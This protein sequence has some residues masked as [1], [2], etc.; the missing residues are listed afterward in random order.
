MAIAGLPLLLPLVT[1]PAGA[2]TAADFQAVLDALARA[3]SRQ[4]TRGALELFTEDALYMQPPDLQLYR[5]REELAKLFGALRP[6]TLM[7][8]HHV[9]LD[10][11]AQV[12]FGEF[13]S[14]HAGAARADHGVVVVGLRDGRI[15]SW[16]EYFQDGPSSFDDFTRVEGKAWKFTAKDLE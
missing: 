14:G 3:W 13:S 7:T 6:G 4:D 9:A 15:A 2:A 11:K 1:P 16:R 10:A 8:F 12:G 5:G